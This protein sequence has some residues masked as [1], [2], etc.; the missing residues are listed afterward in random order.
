MIN[1]LEYHKK[2]G[3]DIRAAWEVNQQLADASA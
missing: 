3:P 1:N 2:G